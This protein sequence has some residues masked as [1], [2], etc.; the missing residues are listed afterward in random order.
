MV[1]ASSL[2]PRTAEL[3]A[4]LAASRSELLAA[5]DAVAVDRRHVRPDPDRWSVDEILEHVAI[6]ES[7]ITKL[8][9]RSVDTAR[10]NGAPREA[11]TSPVVPTIDIARI[12]ARGDRLIASD[13]VRPG[14][15][16]STDDALARLATVR[17]TLIDAVKAADGL[18]IG[19]LTYPHP[20]FGDM[21]L[22]QWVVFVGGHELRHAAQIREIA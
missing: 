16:L 10:A 4:H 18:A 11:D 2:H 6:V 5:V 7:R 22:Y 17:A 14:G 19:H 13:A 8:Y 9:T 21:N 12:V 15:A 20:F 1:N 3:I